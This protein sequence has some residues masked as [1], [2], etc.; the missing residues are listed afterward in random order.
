[1]DYVDYFENFR[2]RTY[3]VHED[4]IA[5]AATAIRVCP[6]LGLACRYRE[7]FPAYAPVRRSFDRYAT[8]RLDCL[9]GCIQQ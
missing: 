4:V 9:G 7:T 8:R 6:L 3:T 1:M 2:V 5:L